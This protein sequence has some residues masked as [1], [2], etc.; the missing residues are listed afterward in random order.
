MLGNYQTL[1]NLLN[2]T[3]QLNLI[4]DHNKIR[5]LHERFDFWT[6]LNLKLDKDFVE[7]FLLANNKESSYEISRESIKNKLKQRTDWL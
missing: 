6:Q 7:P 4:I 3:V 5:K 1:S 2:G